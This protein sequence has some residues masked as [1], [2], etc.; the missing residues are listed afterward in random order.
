MTA[1]LCIATQ[2]AQAQRVLRHL[3][4]TLGWPQGGASQAEIDA[5]KAILRTL[6]AARA[7]LGARDRLSS[8]HPRTLASNRALTEAQLSLKRAIR[9]E[10]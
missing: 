1:P 3:E 10:P 9:G 4:A 6:E 8:E 7:W 5:Q 2:I